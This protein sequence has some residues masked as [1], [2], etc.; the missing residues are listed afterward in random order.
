MTA[1]VW[2]RSSRALAKVDPTRPQPMITTCT[3][4]FLRLSCRTDCAA[5]SP[6]LFVADV[7][8]PTLHR[9]TPPSPTVSHGSRPV[10]WPKVVQPLSVSIG[11]IGKRLLLGR[12]LRLVV[13]SA[14]LVDYVLTVAVSVSSG[15]QN[16]ASAIDVLSGHEALV[17]TILVLPLMSI[18]LRGI[19]ESG[20]A[21]AIPTYAFM[22]CI[23]GM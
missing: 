9:S 22:A 17:A 19:K 5:W 8:D 21:F 10:T 16:A 1:T 20:T 12:T 6:R 13:G 3:A 4:A 23:L 7:A 11:D 15:V 2:P 14:L 18:N